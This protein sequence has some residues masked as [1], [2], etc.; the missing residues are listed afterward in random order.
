MTFKVLN[1]SRWIVSYPKQHFDNCKSKGEPT[2]GMFKPFVRV[3]KNIRS[4][5]IDHDEIEED[6]TTSYFIECLLYNIPDDYFLSSGLDNIFTN[7]LKYLSE[8][9]NTGN[10]L[11]YICANEITLLFGNEQEQKSI[12]NARTLINDL[13]YLWNNW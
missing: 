7:I 12:S 11:N 4:Y 3:F 5:L 8:D 13:N 10:Y 1:E 6:L 9:L 2:K